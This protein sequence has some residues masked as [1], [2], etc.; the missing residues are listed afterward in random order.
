[1]IMANENLIECKVIPYDVEKITLTQIKSLFR[2]EGYSITSVYGYSEEYELTRNGNLTIL[3][4][5][6]GRIKFVYTFFKN[7]KELEKNL[8]EI[9]QNL[10]KMLES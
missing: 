3:D 10:E 4:S 5:N 2:D 1:M 6:E 8:L 7:K 9:G